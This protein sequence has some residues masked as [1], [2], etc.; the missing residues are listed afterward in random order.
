[1]KEALHAERI[2]APS[3]SRDG[4]TREET[5]LPVAYAVVDGEIVSHHRLRR[6]LSRH[7]SGKRPAAVRLRRLPDGTIRLYS[8]AEQAWAAPFWTCTPGAVVLR[9]TCVELFGGY[10]VKPE[11]TR[12]LIGLL[13]D[14]MLAKLTRG[15]SRDEARVRVMRAE[16]ELVG[17]YLGGHLNSRRAP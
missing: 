16:H 6:Y 4:G 8:P 11:T 7:L 13:I 15:R 12:L 3:P 2:A 1:V 14:G 9:E 10:A 5:P 17:A